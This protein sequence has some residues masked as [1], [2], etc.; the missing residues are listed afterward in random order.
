VGDQ[1]PNVDPDFEAWKAEQAANQAA[2]EPPTPSDAEGNDDPE[3][4]S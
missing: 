1:S 2:A 4:V 3:E